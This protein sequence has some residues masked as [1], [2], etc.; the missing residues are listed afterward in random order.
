MKKLFLIAIFFISGAGLLA[1]TSPDWKWIHPRPQAQYVKWVK[2]IDA[3]T[4][5]AAGEYGVF[6]KTT[7]AGTNWTVKT[8]GYPSTLYPGAGIYQN[9]L[10]G[11]FLNANTGFLGVQSVPGILRT[12]NGGQTFD[13]IRILASGSMSTYSFSFINSTTGYLSATSTGKVMKTTDAGL[14]WV[15]LPNLG[16]LTFYAVYA[17]DTNNIITSSSSG[18]VYITTNA[19]QNWT[20][21]NVGTTNTL[22]GMKFLSA[23][24]GYVC[25]SSGCVRYTTNGGF[26]WTGT[27][28]P[29]TS[30]IYYILPGSSDIYAGGTV[31]TQEMFKSTDNGTTWT[32]VSYASGPS[33]TGF[34]AY[35]GDK[36]GNTIFLGGTYGEM[37]KSTDNGTTWSTLMY[38][39]SLANLSGDLYAQSNNGNVIACGVNLGSN[40]AIVNSTDGGNTWSA[41]NFIINSYCSSISMLNP[42]TGFISGRYGM[43]FK[44][45]NGGVS[46]DTSLSWNPALTSYFCNGVDFINANTGWIVGGIPGVGGNTKIFKTT[47]G[48]VNWNEQ[49]SAYTGPVGVKVDMVNANTGYMTHAAGLQK[50]TNG[51]DNWS[52]I[53][54]PG[55]SGTSYTP[56]KVL[57]SINLFTGGNNSQVYGSS[58]GGTTWD[59]LNFP[60]KAG[61]IFCTDWYNSQNGCAGAV[62]GV[63]GKTTNRGQTWQMWNIGGYTVYS[64]RMVHP[65]T[66]F[67]A[68]GNTFGAQIFKYSKG[69]VTGGFTYENKIP[70]SFILKQ[71]YPNPFNPVTTIEFDLPKAGNVSLNIYDLAGRQ[72]SSEI[73]N[74]NLN[75]GNYKMDFNGTQLSSGVYFYSLVVDGRNVATKKMVMVK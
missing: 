45:T 22:Y 8:A 37:I 68:C 59:S 65:D 9:N 26:N 30:S 21:S 57:D 40:D 44:T 55:P 39:K 75:P 23:Q 6:L 60:V 50:T 27:S 11:Y 28:V 70:T 72:Y 53:T 51:G 10:S 71:N 58:N 73:K 20:T 33:I 47:N 41:G 1:Q 36:V 66:I 3:N 24:T 61:T 4:W 49:V 46:W 15:Q 54:N 43:F 63:V 62:I 12:T 14:T 18:N 52:L 31:S 64:V 35:F 69:F 25:G 5:Y 13:T 2:M 34:N 48:G 74:L 42:S 29:T 38:R 32:S 67:A 19:G 16:T 7:N 56:L 17:S